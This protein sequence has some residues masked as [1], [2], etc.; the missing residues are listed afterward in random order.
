MKLTTPLSLLTLL[1]SLVAPPAVQSTCFSL[2]DEELPDC[3]C[4]ETCATCGFAAYLGE[5]TITSD[6]WCLTCNGNLTYSPIYFFSDFQVSAG[7]CVGPNVCTF[8]RLFAQECELAEYCKTWEWMLSPGDTFECFGDP[9]TSM[10]GEFTWAEMCYESAEAEDG[11]PY[12]ETFDFGET[13][14]CSYSVERY[15]FEGDSPTIYNWTQ[16]FTRP[17]ERQGVVIQTH[18]VFECDDPEVYFGDTGYCTEDCHEDLSINGLD[19]N[20]GCTPCPADAEEATTVDCTNVH[21]MLVDT[22]VENDLAVNLVEYFESVNNGS[23]TEP[24]PTST[25]AK[26]T[27][28]VWSVLGCTLA[29]LLWMV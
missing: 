28:N 16:V 13:G 2:P 1:L 12:N 8:D 23:I 5:E 11:V 3:V 17:S 29:A 21:P 24:T 6:T 7:A 18:R 22:C 19:C 4:N 26:A 9:M 25:A 27:D 10:Y 20:A 14:S 15:Y